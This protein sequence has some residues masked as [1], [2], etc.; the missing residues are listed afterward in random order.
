MTTFKIIIA[1]FMAM[2]SPQN[3]RMVGWTSHYAPEV[4]SWQIDYHNLQPPCEGCAI[5]MSD[6]SR[7]GELWFI[8]KID[9]KDYGWIPVV[10]ADCAGKDAI[11]ENG[12]TW[13]DNHNIVAELSYPLAQK[14][15]AVGT[16]IQIEMVKA[17]K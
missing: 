5:A 9:K 4:M 14:L 11:Q 3:E 15:N 8:R 12:K 6:C 1:I 7:I 13:M 2:L 17:E 10:V 16:S